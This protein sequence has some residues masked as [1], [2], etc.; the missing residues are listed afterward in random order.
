LTKAIPLDKLRQ[1]HFQPKW[2][3][4]GF[5]KSG[6]HWLSL[7]LMP[8]AK[9]QVGEHEIWDLPWAGTFKLNS[10]SNQEVSLERVTYLTGRLQDGFF[11]KAH[12]AYSKEL[13]RFLWYLGAA[14]VFIYRDFRDVAVSQAFHVTSEGDERLAHP[15]KEFYGDM[16][17]FGSV[18]RAVIEG[19]T[20]DNGFEYPGVM[21][22]WAHYAGWLDVDW[23][24]KVR[25]EDVLEN[26]RGTAVKIV[27]HG[28]SRAC[29]IF[30]LKPE[31]VEENLGV[32][33]DMMVQAGAMTHLSPTFRKGARG[34]WRECFTPELARLFAETDDQN[35]L[36]RLGYTEEGWY[37]HL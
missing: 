33:A 3:L 25:Y 18:L 15:E 8:I 11:L 26:P 30:G 23:I 32:V 12:S 34:D 7:A 20:S 5:P 4:N 37:G 35:W 21:S 17:G 13:E 24:C 1:E 10:W 28:L 6:L 19:V 31:V 16:D 36:V 14:V 29:G 27:R 22:R 2:Y 9:P